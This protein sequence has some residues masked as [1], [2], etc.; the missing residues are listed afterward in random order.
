MH[1]CTLFVAFP[2]ARCERRRPNVEVAFGVFVGSFAKSRRLL[3][4]ARQTP[5]TSR[6]AIA[7]PKRGGFPYFLL[8]KDMAARW[9][10]TQHRLSDQFSRPPI[11]RGGLPVGE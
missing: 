4:P 7:S 10:A 9:F 3:P 11:L 6:H 1:L 5:W 8:L 2:Y